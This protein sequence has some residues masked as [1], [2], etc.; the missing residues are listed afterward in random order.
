MTEERNPNKV[1]KMVVKSQV[2]KTKKK[3]RTLKTTREQ[4]TK[5]Q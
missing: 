5:W 1:L 3:H 4:L 2:K